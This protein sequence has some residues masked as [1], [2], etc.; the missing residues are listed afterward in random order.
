MRRQYCTT[1]YHYLE[2]I[3]G[4][5]LPGFTVLRDAGGRNRQ[6]PS[7][8]RCFV[9][10]WRSSVMMGYCSGKDI[11]KVLS[12]PSDAG[13]VSLL[14]NARREQPHFPAAKAAAILIS[15][16][17][18]RMRPKLSEMLFRATINTTFATPWVQSA[19]VKNSFISYQVKMMFAVPP[20][21]CYTADTNDAP[22]WFTFHTRPPHFCFT[23]I[24]QEKKR[25][26][27]KYC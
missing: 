8:F 9:L 23:K 22:R 6:A 15:D 24:Y 5:C 13:V 14:L 12:A 27:W 25:S 2:Y 20:A 11:W 21:V 7:A 19:T 17:T 26:R 4:D 1:T 3:A 16:V 10:R 18:L